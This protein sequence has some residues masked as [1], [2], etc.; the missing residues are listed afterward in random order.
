LTQYVVS[1]MVP[2]VWGSVLPVQASAPISQDVSRAD[3][4]TL[5]DGLHASSVGVGSAEL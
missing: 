1:D 3:D 5:T 4:G 2:Q